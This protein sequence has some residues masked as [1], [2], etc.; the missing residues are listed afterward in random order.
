MNK[1]TGVF[2]Y[3]ATG[4]IDQDAKTMTFEEGISVTN[5]F[6]F[7][8]SENNLSPNTYHYELKMTCFILRLKEIEKR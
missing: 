6:F 3:E 2:S 1:D 7:P 8:L 4:S 5:S